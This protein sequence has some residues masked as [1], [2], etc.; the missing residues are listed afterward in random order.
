MKIDIAGKSA[1]GGRNAQEDCY[2]AYRLEEQRAHLNKI[3]KQDVYM[4]VLCDGMGG[5][6]DGDYCSSKVVQY[7]ADSFVETGSFTN[8]WKQRL[9]MSLYAAN[10]ALHDAKECL[11]DL[12]ARSGCTL[13]AAA[14]DGNRLHFV[15]VGDSFIWLFRKTPDHYY[16]CELL[17]TRHVSWFKFENNQGGV[18]IT[19]EEAEELQR[20]PRDGVCLKDMP[21]SAVIGDVI[22]AASLSASKGIELQ[23]GDFVVLASDGVERELDKD[24]LCRLAYN[25]GAPVYSAKNLA[26]D[27][28]NA[29][30]RQGNPKR[31]NASCV[32]FKC[33]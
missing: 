27:I 23:P 11:P 18:P 29:V 12:D 9:I 22:P 7:F 2:M 5:E 13:V 10:A 32:V 31:D 33:D 15:S 26:D 1:I 30:A 25:V 8:G 17:N 14:V 4:G 3:L 6:G 16:G 28:I 20:N 19:A 21:N 24:E